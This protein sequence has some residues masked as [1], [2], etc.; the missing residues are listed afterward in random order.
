MHVNLETKLN[1]KKMKF[2][3]IQCSTTVIKSCCMFKVCPS[4]RP[5]TLGAFNCLYRSIKSCIYE[6]KK[7]NDLLPLKIIV[8]YSK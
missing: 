5:Q 1:L 3:T 2:R 8:Y 4:R 6:E 7:I